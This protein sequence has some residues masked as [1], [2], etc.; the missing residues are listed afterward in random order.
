[1]DR[2]SQATLKKLV[3]RT[4]LTASGVVREGLRSLEER[5]AEQE[6]SNRSR[7]RLIGA[8]EFD[9]GATDL[10]TNKGHME[11]FGKKWRVDKLGKGRWDW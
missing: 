8:G 3:K 10:A 5:Y 11:G 4:K 1:L 6:R 2:K 7:P 9:F